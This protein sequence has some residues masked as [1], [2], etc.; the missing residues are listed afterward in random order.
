MNFLAHY[1]TTNKNIAPYKLLG[2]ALPDIAKDF[3]KIYNNQLEQGLVSELPHIQEMLE[4]IK[5]HIKGDDMF[6]NHRIFRINEM[7]AKVV[8]EMEDEITVKRKFVIAH[9][10]IELMIDQYIINHFPDELEKF[11]KKI[12][13][14]DISKANEL[15]EILKVKEDES[16]FLNNFKHFKDQKFLYHLKEN[17]GVLLTLNKVFGTI[18]AYDFMENKDVWM[19]VIEEIKLNLQIELPFLLKELKEKLNA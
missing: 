17:E 7:H 14:I 8:L 15:F 19:N 10:I 2:L 4:G 12:D 3:S 1:H 5:L 6:H 11:Y 16:H 18:F 13:M 9:V